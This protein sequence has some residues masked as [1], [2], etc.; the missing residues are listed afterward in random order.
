METS[1][2]DDMEMTVVV[3]A[4]LLENGGRYEL[5][6]LELSVELGDV[7]DGIVVPNDMWVISVLD[8]VEITEKETVFE[9]LE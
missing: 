6:S 9:S 4:K 7:S 2:C 3:L 1:I 5:R 8:P